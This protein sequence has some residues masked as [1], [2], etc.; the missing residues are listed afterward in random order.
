MTTFDGKTYDAGHDRERLRTL[1]GR[2]TVKMSSGHWWT[3]TQLARICG[4][5]E[6]GVSAR[7]RD[8]RKPKFGGY[9]IERRRVAGGLWQY[10]M[11]KP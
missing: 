8:L 1:L 2:V 5:S 9:Q 6:A 7:I 10:R 11:V 4:G 3:I